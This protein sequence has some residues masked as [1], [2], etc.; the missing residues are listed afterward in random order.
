[1]VT[2]LGICKI[3]KTK[4]SMGEIEAGH[5]VRWLSNTSDVLV[6]KL[7]RQHLGVLV[8]RVAAHASVMRTQCRCR[9]YLGRGVRRPRSNLTALHDTIVL[10]FISPCSL[11]LAKTCGIPCGESYHDLVSHV[12]F[13]SPRTTDSPK[14][15]VIFT[16]T[17]MRVQL[18]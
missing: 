16:I 13:T 1:M 14:Q 6:W 11:P 18:W 10:K 3:A 15:P 5:N 8:E 9:A 2:R 4:G 7:G 12:V 17:S